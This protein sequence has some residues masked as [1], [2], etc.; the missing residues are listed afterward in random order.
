MKKKVT[1]PKVDP[2]KVA[3]LNEGVGKNNKGV[4]KNIKKVTTTLISTDSTS[5][6]IIS[7][8]KWYIRLWRIVSN[9]FNFIFT[10]KIKY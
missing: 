5:I 3:I 4:G 8:A 2:T 7:T 6:I 10:G 1:L 9:P